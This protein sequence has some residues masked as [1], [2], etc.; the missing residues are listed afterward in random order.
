MISLEQAPIRVLI[1][2]DHPSVL[3]GLR[4]LIDS[5]EPRMRVVDQATCR[6]EAF[7]ALRHD[8]DV[9]LLDLDLGDDNGLDMVAQLRE[10]SRAKVIILTGMRDPAVCDQALLQGAAG[11]VHKS[12]PAEVILKAIAH[13]HEGELWMDR[14]TTAR[15]FERMSGSAK[16]A[17]SS[18]DALLTDR[19]RGIVSAVVKHK[20]A[21]GKIIADALHISGHTL[22]NHLASIYGKLGVHRRLDLVLF[23]MENGLDKRV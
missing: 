4:K 13:V 21:P 16:T 2:D 5:E 8:P 11:L 12:Q 19:E 20:G 9:I 3:W 17:A 18:P 15:V 1:V 6:Q 23:A 22:R 7:N 10:Q 14:A